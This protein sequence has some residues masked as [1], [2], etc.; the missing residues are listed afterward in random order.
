MSNSPGREMDLPDD[1]AAWR[2]GVGLCR[3]FSRDVIEDFGENPDW[4]LEV[5]GAGGKPLFR[6]RLVAEKLK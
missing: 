3:D 1:C 4:T 2:E 6:F 5:T